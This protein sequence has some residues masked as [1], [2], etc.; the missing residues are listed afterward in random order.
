MQILRKKE[1]ETHVEDIAVRSKDEELYATD[2]DAIL[3]RRREGNSPEIC[4]ACACTHKQL[5]MLVE[6][7]SQFGKK[8]RGTFFRLTIS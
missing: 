6:E 1:R 4:I 7:A 5:W 3:S 2:D 8:I